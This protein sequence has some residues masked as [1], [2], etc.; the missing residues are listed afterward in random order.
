[1]AH[2]KTGSQN[3]N[4][5]VL[6]I[7]EEDLVLEG[8]EH[9]LSQATDIELLEATK[10]Y[11]LYA[12]SRLASAPEIIIVEASWLKNAERRKWLLDAKTKTR[13][14]IIAVIDSAKEAKR[15]R[16]IG[17]VDEAIQSPFSSQQLIHLIRGLSRDDKSLCMY[18][19]EQLQATP[20]GNK[21]FDKYIELVSSI[22]QLTFAQLLTN[23]RIKKTSSLEDKF[24]Y[25]TFE[26]KSNHSFWSELRKR[27]GTN[28]I[29]FSMQ[30]TPASFE[31]QIWRLGK[32][33]TEPIG[34]LGFINNR[35]PPGDSLDMLQLSIYANE[36]K[37]IIMLFDKQI[38]SLLALK[39]AGVEPT[40]LI[41]DIYQ[42]LIIATTETKR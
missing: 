13:T 5:K 19:A 15:V 33:L 32:Y 20:P 40:E 38:R 30:N 28:Y 25:L 6:L 27:F 35:Q 17:V 26:N 14:K 1:M 31:K 3:S 23:P 42:E 4:I 29:I 41:E 2:R 34:R 9:A 22:L 37:I 24:V 39:A 7:A 8:W 12:R 16:R 18:Y 11:L 36:G 21:H 10:K